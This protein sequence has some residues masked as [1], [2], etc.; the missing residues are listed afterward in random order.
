MPHRTIETLIRNQKLVTAQKNSTVAETALLMRQCMI[1]AVIVVEE[2]RLSGIFTERDGLFRVI[3]QGRD[4]QTT[5]LGEVM[6]RDPETITADQP[7]GHALH[8]MYEGGFRHV[9]VVEGKVP[10]GMVSARDV[11][12]R[13]LEEFACDLQR[14]EHIVEIL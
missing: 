11:L 13:E 7:F 4:P 14:R 9:P 3:A 5:P 2:G 1:G 6:T 12:G 10:V 8:M